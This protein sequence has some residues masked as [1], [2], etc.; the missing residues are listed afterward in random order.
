[1][2]GIEIVDPIFRTYVLG[3]AP[4]ETLADGFRWLEGPVWFGDMNMLVFSD[5]PN[6]RVMRWSERDGVLVFRQPSQFANGHARDREGRLVTCS[7]RARNVTRLE[8][9]GSVTVL[10]DRYAGK[11]L[12]A[13]NDIVVKGDGTIWFTDPHYGLQTD[14]EGGK[15]TPE[16]PPAV[17]RLDPR[18]GRLDVVAD[19]FDEPNGLAFSPDERTLYISETGKLFDETPK[20]MIRAFDVAE[21]GTLARGRTF[22]K[23]APGFAD[24]FRCDEHGNL[25][26][27][28]AD[29]VHCISPQG[30]LLGKI[31]VPSTVSNVAFGDRHRSRLFICA[32]RTLY[33]I[34]L[35]VRGATWPQDR[36]KSLPPSNLPPEDRTSRE[37]RP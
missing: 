19:D 31:L 15:Q 22:H 2:D 24:G 21:D 5:L 9:D 18:D 35:N 6:D 14:Y 23:V 12:N 28:A 26:S 16:L 30:A 29:G 7:H 11:R 25:W 34:F 27:S 8:H 36:T 37:R 1:M 10:A 33:A 32:S 13:P 17:F 20:Q 3:N 4:L